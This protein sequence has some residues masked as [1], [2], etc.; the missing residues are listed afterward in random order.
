MYSFFPS[1]SFFSS[2]VTN[3]PFSA[4]VAAAIIPAAPPPIT[5]MRI[6]FPF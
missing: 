4:A 3:A 5:A 6:A 2:N 1:F